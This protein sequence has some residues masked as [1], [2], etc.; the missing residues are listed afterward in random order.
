LAAAFE[1]DKGYRRYRK[2]RSTTLQQ[3][4]PARATTKKQ[5]NNSDLEENEVQARRQR[6]KMQ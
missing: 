1:V 3:S 6:Y 4:A 5:Y 2:A